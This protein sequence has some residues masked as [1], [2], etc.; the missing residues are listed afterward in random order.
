M[1]IHDDAHR[2]EYCILKTVPHEH[3]LAQFRHEGLDSLS[4][5]AFHRQ[6][7]GSLEAI[8]LDV[9][10]IATLQNLTDTSAALLQMCL[11]NLKAIGKV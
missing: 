4:D 1:V 2:I 7:W 11:S 6:I 8:R 9:I 10:M 3:I 5:K